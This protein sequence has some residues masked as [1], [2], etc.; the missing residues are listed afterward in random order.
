MAVSLTGV[1]CDT[2]EFIVFGRCMLNDT[3]MAKAIATG[4]MG[5]FQMATMPC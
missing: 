5:C 4:Y 3:K 1:M 2:C